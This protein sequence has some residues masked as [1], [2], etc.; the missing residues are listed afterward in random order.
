MKYF[1][2]DNE[3]ESTCYHEFYKGK[4]D[5]S[6]FWREDSLCLHDAVMIENKGFEDAIMEVIPT[7][8][9]FGET[10]VSIEAWEKIGQIIRE[11][12]ERSQ[13][14]YQEANVWVTDVFK[15]YDCF[16]ILGI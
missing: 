15:E 16:T 9:P 11:K 10:E 1:V 8:D 7:Y 3:R 6:T 2:T 14:L 13:E 5:G 4:W 12:D